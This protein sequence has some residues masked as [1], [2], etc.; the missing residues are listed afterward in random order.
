MD[1]GLS[2]ASSDTGKATECSKRTFCASVNVFFSLGC[3]F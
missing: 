3:V 1:I 2:E